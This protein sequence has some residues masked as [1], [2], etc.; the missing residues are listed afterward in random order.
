[1]DFTRIA[2]K[3]IKIA[4]IS[5]THDNIALFVGQIA[6]NQSTSAS[7]FGVVVRSWSLQRLSDPFL[8]MYYRF[9]A[10]SSLLRFL[11][12]PILLEGQ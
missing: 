11:S 2:Q 3:K 5:D 6:L 12:L 9:S 4:M 7:H 1:M 10:Q 8:K